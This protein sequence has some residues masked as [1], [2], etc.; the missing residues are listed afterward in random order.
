MT[1]NVSELFRN[2][3]RFL[4]LEQRVL[5]ELL[6][7]PTTG[8]KLWSA[9][10]SYGAEVYSLAVLANE[11]APHARHELHAY[12]IDERVLA[13]ARLGRFGSADMRNVTPQ[14]RSRWFVEEALDGEPVPLETEPADEPGEGWFDHK[15]VTRYLQSVFDIAWWELP[16]STGAILVG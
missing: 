4:E 10:C 14:R 16:D 3:E 7:S 8:L 2:P 12:D 9:G 1:I 5:P 6:R 11:C 15:A 13:R